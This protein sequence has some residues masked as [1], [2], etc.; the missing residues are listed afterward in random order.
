[1]PKMSTDLILADL[2]LTDLILTGPTMGTTWSATLPAQPLSP[3]LQAAL[4]A[5]VTEVDRIATTWS[6]TSDLMRLNTAAPDTWVTLPPRLMTILQA[7]LAMGA[8]TDGAFDAALGDAVNAW[9]FGPDQACITKIHAARARPRRPAHETLELDLPN[10]R[11]RKHQ[12]LQLDLSGIAKGYGVDR[13]T[14]VLMDH[15]IPAALLA[16]D[17]ELRALGTRSDGTPWTIAVERPSHTSRTPHSILMLQN[18]AVAT[19]GDYRHWVQ[20]GNRLLSHTINPKTGAPLTDAPASVTVVGPDCMWSDAVAT[21]LMV[22]G[23]QKGSAFAKAQG[24]NALFL[25][26]QADQITALPIGPI[27]SGPSFSGP[28]FSGPV[29]SGP[30]FSGPIYS[31][32]PSLTQ[33]T[34]PLH[35]GPNTHLAPP[36]QGTAPEN[37]PPVTG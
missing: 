15:T 11:A 13:L 1:M 36:P 24:I 14:E 29:N 25:H 5:A 27:F 18:A 30:I 8:E 2:I 16:I 22:M 4:Q 32:P 35:T 6:P 10:H 23:T 17:G 31:G 12:P 3:T 21:A 19:S 26:R 20:V 37:Q 7:A 34:L 28:I 33:R 9:G